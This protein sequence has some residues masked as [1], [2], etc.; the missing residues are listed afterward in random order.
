MTEEETKIT[1][2]HLVLTLDR[3]D[4]WL[5]AVRAGLEALPQD[6]EIEIDP[7]EMKSLMAAKLPQIMFPC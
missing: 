7:D 1:V 6:Q 5:Q 3:V 4:H 2:A